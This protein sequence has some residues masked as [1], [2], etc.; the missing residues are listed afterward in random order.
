VSSFDQVSRRAKKLAAEGQIGEAIKLY[1]LFLQ[2]F[3]KNTRAKAALQKL[4]SNVSGNSS[5]AQMSY[6]TAKNL[7]EK[8][9]YA[10]GIAKAE[11]LVKE[12]PGNAAVWNLLGLAYFRSNN[13][14]DSERCLRKALEIDKN[15][16]PAWINIGTLFHAQ[17]RLEQALTAFQNASLLDPNNGGLCNSIGGILISLR[18]FE[19]A[20][21]FCVRAIKHAPNFADAY[22][23]LAILFYRRE[24]LHLAKQAYVKVLQLMP[25]NLRALGEYLYIRAKLCDWSASEI[26]LKDKQPV[27]EVGNSMSPFSMLHCEDDPYAQRKRSEVHALELSVPNR[28]PAIQRPANR[29]A[30][31]KVAYFSADFHNHA[32]LSLMMGVMAAHDKNRFE[33][34]AY[35]YGAVKSGWRRDKLQKMIDKNWEVHGA[36]DEEIVRHAREQQFDIAVDLKGYTD[37]G[38]TRLF[39]HRLAP[40]QINY[41]GYPGT[42]AADFIDYMIADHTVIPDQYRDAYAE[43]LIYMPHCYQPNDNERKFEENTQS[44][45]DLGL[46]DTGFVF[47]SFNACYKISPREFDIWMRLLQKVDGS[48]LWLFKGSD[49]AVHNL[50]KEAQLRGVNPDRLVFAGMVSEEEHLAR[51]K[52]ADLFLDTFNVNAH[53]TA[54]DALWAGL[55]I[56]TLPGKQF[57]ARVAASILTAANL[58]ELVAQTEEEYEAIA[59]DLA[60]NPEKA[61][62][63]KQKLQVQLKTC[64][65]FDTKS[66]TRALEAGYEAAYDR[67][68]SDQA[69]ADIDVMPR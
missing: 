32:T 33:I 12:I 59:L 40:V 29:P 19:E 27:G 15:Q 47:S 38:R 50:K 18:R 22:N 11:Q 68:F 66:Y 48:V 41:L 64:P 39:A 55:P 69:P 10:Q 8:G 20:E 6:A 44:R 31:L 35:S 52:H 21:Q 60:L 9:E 65:L 58:S 49:E 53:T 37:H 28:F 14:A 3:P 1:E 61:A 56:V 4:Q 46:P 36:S 63:L 45:G 62:A 13:P 57:A 51:Q 30:R 17:N 43:K 54:S 34:H 5:A 25:N 7:I 42:L 24:K 26:E 2:D 23:N 16:G 67:Y